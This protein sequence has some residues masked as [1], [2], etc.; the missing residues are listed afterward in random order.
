MEALSQREFDRWCETDAEFKRLMGSH[1]EAQ[2]KLNLDT[3]RR[4][5]TVEAEQKNCNRRSSWVS[6]IV[7]A[8][9]G[10]I[11]GAFAGGVK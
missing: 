1:I 11:V 10:G 9:V 5:A 7:S 8:V 4:L 3:E 2:T 6:G